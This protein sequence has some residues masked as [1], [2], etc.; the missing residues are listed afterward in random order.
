MSAARRQS[1]MLRGRSIFQQLSNSSFGTFRKVLEGLDGV[2][3]KDFNLPEVIVIGAESSGKSSLLEAI[4]KCPV[5]PRNR[6]MCTRMP[7]RLKLTNA[8]SG[9]GED[10][11]TI[12]YGNERH[13]NLTT[14]GILELVESIMNQLPSDEISDTELVI[15]IKQPNIPTF[16]FIDLPGIRSFPAQ[17]AR[18][19]VKLVNKYLDRQNTLVICVVPAPTQRLTAVQAL[20]MIHDK[21]KAEQ[22]V[23]ALTMTDR[24]NIENFHELVLDR[25]TGRSDELRGTG[26][27]DC[28]AIVNR[29]DEDAWTLE[30]VD[31]EEALWFENTI[32][33][34]HIPVAEVRDN[35]SLYSLVRKIDA[36]Y[37]HFIC[38]TWKPAALQKLDELR[39]TQ[40][41]KRKVLGPAPEVVTVSV[42][43]SELLALLR[44][45]WL[46]MPHV[47]GPEVSDVLANLL[48]TSWGSRAWADGL[49]TLQQQFDDWVE[50]TDGSTL[51]AEEV[52]A[53]LACAFNADTEMKTERFEAARIA[54]LEHAKKTRQDR[55]HTLMP[56]IHQYIVISFDKMH[57]M[58]VTE[59]PS[60]IPCI[61]RDIKGLVVVK[62]LLPVL[63]SVGKVSL[64]GKIIEN[65]HYKDQRRDLVELVKKQEHAS[66]V[67][68]NIE[69]SAI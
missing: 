41:Q 45:S 69:D 30:E 55:L 13:V 31:R 56:L 15:D 48:C 50:Q 67:I 59:L 51:L 26:L 33:Q 63:E 40:E 3:M 8:N 43:R 23:V 37:H 9:A 57:G 4:T 42:L 27:Q 49:Q 34:Q 25:I 1:P 11:V 7:I 29:S 68:S 61:Q 5:F 53:M 65:N 2:D 12:T 38:R 35:L 19:T 28:I 17:L 60:L 66:S 6:S 16:T 52:Q 36:L 62:I 44:D 39:Q 22:T 21:G 54:V 58:E 10:E 47:L 64:E 14:D 46:P 32:A 18:D 24:V 20:G